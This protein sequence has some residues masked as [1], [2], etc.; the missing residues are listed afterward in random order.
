VLVVEDEDAV[1]RVVTSALESTGYRVIEARSG[2]EALEL[3]R[4]RT[5]GIHLVVT[6]VVMPEMSGRELVERLRL[7]HRGL[8]ILYM[9][10]YT[11]DA[12]VRHGVVESGVAFLQKPFSLLTLAR[13]VREVLDGT[14][15][16][17]PQGSA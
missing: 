2:S 6:D 7:E 17:P 1:R 8:R 11:D 13:K 5:G 14:L 12:V 9:S 4:T 10:G 15:S 3:A 16:E